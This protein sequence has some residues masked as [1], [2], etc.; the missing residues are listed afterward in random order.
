MTIASSLPSY[1]NS[2]VWNPSS[3][4]KAGGSRP[5]HHR[6]GDLAS[7]QEIESAIPGRF[8]VKR[9]IPRGVEVNGVGQNQARQGVYGPWREQVP[10]A[11]LGL[12]CSPSR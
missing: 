3:H 9:P 4:H 2:T 8:R 6:H 1:G 12:F 11:A 10:D 7:V 5:P